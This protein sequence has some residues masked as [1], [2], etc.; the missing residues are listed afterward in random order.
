MLNTTENFKPSA[1]KVAEVCDK[2]FQLKYFDKQIFGSL[3]G[4]ASTYK[5]VISERRP[6]PHH[7]TSLYIEKG[8]S[9]QIPLIFKK[10]EWKF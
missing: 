2:S 10:A 1:L 9:L 8:C 4:L 7:G 5:C 3:Y 6:W